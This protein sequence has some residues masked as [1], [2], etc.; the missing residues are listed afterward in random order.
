M[1]PETQEEIRIIKEI[2]EHETLCGEYEEKL[3]KRNE[4]I[5][6]LQ[7]V[8][9]QQAQEIERLKKRNSNL[10]KEYNVRTKEKDELANQII[11]LE[12]QLKQAVEGVVEITKVC[13][14]SPVKTYQRMDRIAHEILSHIKRG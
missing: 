14:D 11:Q 9:E 5:C 4:E 3:T 1:K 10:L 2:K 7:D 6:S 13:E 12:E 8:G